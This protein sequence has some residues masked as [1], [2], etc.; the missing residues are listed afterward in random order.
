[1]WFM[2]IYLFFCHS[3]P[4]ATFAASY[5][6]WYQIHQF[7]IH[8]TQNNNIAFMNV[9]A[10]WCPW[11]SLT[12]LISQ[13]IDWLSLYP[14]TGVQCVWPPPTRQPLTQPGEGLPSILNWWIQLESQVVTV[15]FSQEI[16]ACLPP[17][18]PSANTLKTRSGN[19]I[20]RQPFY[21]FIWTVV[22]STPNSGKK[23]L[24]HT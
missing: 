24:I 4:L 21:N 6:D 23:T 10:Q 12:N 3:I 7:R 2:Y 1:M 8:L 13:V 20:C 11:D 9:T 17:T 16:V 18:P 15:S 5:D 22:I 14:K 19:K